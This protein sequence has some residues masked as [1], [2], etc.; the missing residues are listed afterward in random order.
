MRIRPF[1]LYGLCGFDCFRY[2]MGGLG[3]CASRPPSHD[4]LRS[5]VARAESRI[6]RTA[7]ADMTVP[8][9]RT[10]LSDSLDQ[11][12]TLAASGTKDG[13]GAMADLLEDL[14]DQ[15]RENARPADQSRE[16]R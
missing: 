4:R 15:V 7:G 3:A 6:D 16:S 8:Y 12:R 5:L 1:G 11:A 14:M 10:R 13:T 2:V 9:L